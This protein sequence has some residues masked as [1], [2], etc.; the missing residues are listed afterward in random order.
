MNMISLAQSGFAAIGAYTAVLLTM[1]GQ[2]NLFVLLAAAIITS[3]I[4]GLLLAVVVAKV[5]GVYFVLVSFAF[6]GLITS[7]ITN[8]PVLGGANGFAGIPSIT[9]W[10][11]WTGTVSLGDS[12]SMLQVIVIVTTLIILVAALWT[13][14]FRQITQSIHEDENLSK[15]LGLDVIKFRILGLCF[16]A[17]IAG[18]GGLL[19]AFFI[20]S[21]SPDTFYW[22]NSVDY[23][24]FNIVG[25]TGAL[26]GPIMG[27]ILLEGFAQSFSSLIEYNLG[28][29]G[30]VLILFSTLFRGGIYGMI[31]GLRKR[32]NSSNRAKRDRRS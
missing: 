13:M 15:S 25:G 14:K 29:F 3:A 5:R 11:P 22:I 10:L 8:T 18:V 9:L 2:T 4:A 30:L 17:A 19:L 26:I 28:L 12:Q 24:A 6:T 27:T 7:I 20:T 21:I 16:S 23:L 31:E 32:I 1:Q